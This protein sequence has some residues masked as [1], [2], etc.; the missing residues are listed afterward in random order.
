MDLQNHN[1]ISPHLGRKAKVLATV[2][3]GK[4]YGDSSKIKN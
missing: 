3:M 1:E 2:I 4:Q